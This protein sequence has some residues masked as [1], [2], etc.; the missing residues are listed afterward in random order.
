VPRYSCAK[1]SVRH[2]ATKGIPK[3]GT[4]HSCTQSGNQLIL[5]NLLILAMSAF[6]EDR[7]TITGSHMISVDTNSVS[8]NCRSTPGYESVNTHCSGH[9]VYRNYLVTTGLMSGLRYEMTCR[10]IFSAYGCT[11]PERHVPRTL[12]RRERPGSLERQEEAPV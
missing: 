8:L 4:T 11:L 5:I 12:D 10:A 9:E 6:A 7:I 3:H 1:F 2:P